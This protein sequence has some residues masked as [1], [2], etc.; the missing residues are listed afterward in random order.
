MRKLVLATA[1]LLAM[2]VGSNAGLI[3]FQVSEDAGP[4]TTI[5]T[6]QDAAT[7][8]PITFG[9]FGIASLSGATDPFLTLP[10]LLQGQQISVSSAAP[11]EHTLHLTVLGTG[12]TAPTGLQTIA[13]GFDVTGI[14]AGWSVA[15]STDINGTIIGSH[16]FIGPLSSGADTDFLNFTL[17]STFFA[18]IH[19]DINNFIAG[20]GSVGV[21]GESNTGAAIAA[22][23]GPIVGAGLPGIVTG[24][25]GL[26]GWKRRKRRVA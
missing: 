7:L 12:L 21:A 16:T 22:V 4:V 5:N 1:S 24:L 18:S 23:P 13:S 15:E 9:D 26:W 14:S 17:P 25:V 20:P 3:T 19:F 2:T 6:G 8:G 10:F 11:G